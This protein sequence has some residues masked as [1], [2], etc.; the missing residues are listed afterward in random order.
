MSNERVFFSLHCRKPEYYRKSVDEP[1]LSVLA[2][3]K[4]SLSDLSV[5]QASQHAFSQ[6]SVLSSEPQART[7]SIGLPLVGQSVMRHPLMRHQTFEAFPSMSAEIRTRS[8]ERNISLPTETDGS[9]HVRM[10]GREAEVN[11]FV[12]TSTLFWDEE[13]WISEKLLLAKFYA[14]R[15][16]VM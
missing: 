13:F 4:W 6:V 5:Q 10:H 9:F 15:P 3:W 7:S 1:W 8:L 14:F 2:A 16:H 11:I 12:N